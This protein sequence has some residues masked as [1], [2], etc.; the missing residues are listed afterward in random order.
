M[1]PLGFPAAAQ[2]RVKFSFSSADTGQK[3]PLKHAEKPFAADAGFQDN[4]AS[5]VVRNCAHPCG[6]PAAGKCF[7]DL[8]GFF[9]VS[10]RQNADTL[11]FVC[12]IQGIYAQE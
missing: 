3:S 1:P 4:T 10:F 9:R 7:H 2:R 5:P 11:A 8:K 6:F 12:E